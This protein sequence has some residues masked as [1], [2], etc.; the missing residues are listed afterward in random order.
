ML[1]DVAVTFAG[2]GDARGRCWRVGRRGKPVRSRCRNPASSL[3]G[4]ALLFPALADRLAKPFVVFG[5][6]RC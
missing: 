5:A 3:F 2:G 4:L 6:R 1:I